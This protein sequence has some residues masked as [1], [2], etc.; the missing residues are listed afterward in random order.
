MKRKR[1]NPEQII[2]KLRTADQ[3]LNQGQAVADVCRAL[4]VSAATYHRW[5]QQL[6]DGMKATEAKRLKEL[7]QE[8]SRLKRL[9]ADA[10]LDKAM[11]KELFGGKLLSPERRRRAVMVLQDRFRLSQRRACRLAGQNRNTQRR[12]VPVAAIEEHKLRQRIRELARRHVRWGRRLVYRRLRIEGWSVNHKRVQRLWR[13]EGLQRPTPRKQKRARPADGSVRRHRAEHPHQVWAMDF[14]FDATADGRRLKFLNVI[15]EH[16][17]LCLAIR[18]GRR[19]K[20]KD[21]VAVLEELTS[22]YPAPA[23]IRSDNSPEFIAKALR[24]WCE[25]STTTSTA[26]IAPGSPWENGFAES[27]NGRFRDEFL[28]TELF[29]TAPEAQILAD[30]W[31]WEYNSLRP[32]SALQGLT[33]LEAAQQGAA[34]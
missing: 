8:N 15:D 5:R 18:V 20:A 17:R 13:E 16:S 10:E 33:P 2:R 11:L 1:H 26:Y 27:F 22:L 31:R 34:A 6:Y 12:P 25:A 19:C 9:L 24:D 28:N 32:H 4:E 7:E 29:T 30:R 14:Q 3:L 21:V 23:F